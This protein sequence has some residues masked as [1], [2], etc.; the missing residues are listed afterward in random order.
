MRV[1]VFDY[2]VCDNRE[3]IAQKLVRGDDGLDDVFADILN[4]TC[5]QNQ[6]ETALTAL[7]FSWMTKLM[8]PESPAA[9]ISLSA[10][11]L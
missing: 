7:S 3:L 2:V 9:V 10:Q 8:S 1:V 4:N 6:C 11:K 5:L